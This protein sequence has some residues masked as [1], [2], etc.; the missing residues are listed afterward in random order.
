MNTDQN[1]NVIQITGAGALPQTVWAGPNANRVR[2][3]RN[4]N[5][6]VRGGRDAYFQQS[7]S[8]LAAEFAPPQAPIRAGGTDHY[9]S[10]E[11]GEYVFLQQVN[12][13]SNWTFE[14]L[15]N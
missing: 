13:D 7:A 9:I 3:T 12:D 10:T 8:G 15:V 2:L 11:W 4:R 14:E 5:Y 1:G 6:R